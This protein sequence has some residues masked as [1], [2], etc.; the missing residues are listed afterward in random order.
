MRADCRSGGVSLGNPLAKVPDIGRCHVFPPV[1]GAIPPAAVAAGSGG[2]ERTGGIHGMYGMNR[3][4]RAS[5][6]SIYSILSMWP[7]TPRPRPLG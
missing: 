5:N 1:C 4:T 7:L 2:G 3:V 6:L